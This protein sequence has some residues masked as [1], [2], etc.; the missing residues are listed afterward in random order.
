ML[1]KFMVAAGLL[2][3]TFTG[4]AAPADAKT[5]VIIDLGL[6]GYCP[7][8]YYRNNGRCY[9]RYDEPR[10]D[11]DEPRYDDGYDSP[12]YGV[13]EP[14]RRTYRLSCRDVRRK[15]RND[16]WRRVEAQDC[17]GRYY[18]FIAWR[19]GS[20]YELRVSSKNGRV[21]SRSPL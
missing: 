7:D 9:P 21:V 13:Y 17:E 15:L 6:G 14:P 1:M 20:P 16:G 10:Y 5:K 12:G 4:L 3:A 19:R 2:A 18:S 11:Y 8:G